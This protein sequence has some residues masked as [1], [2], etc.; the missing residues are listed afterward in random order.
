MGNLFLTVY[1]LFFGAVLSAEISTHHFSGLYLYTTTPR[2]LVP[3]G[4]RVFFLI[5]LRLVYLGRAYSILIC[6]PSFGRNLAFFFQLIICA[7]LSLPVFG[8]AQ[9][10][11]RI[12]PPPVIDPPKQKFPS[13]NPI[14]V[15]SHAHCLAWA[16]FSVLPAALMLLWILYHC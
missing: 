16:F 14:I 15:Y 5:V 10:S 9:L 7:V 2:P 3:L 8:I 11:Y 13:E 6:C 12:E 1:I 4:V